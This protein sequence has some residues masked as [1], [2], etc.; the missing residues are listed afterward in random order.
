MDRLKQS[1]GSG[2]KLEWVCDEEEEDPW[3]TQPGTGTVR[4]D[5][6]PGLGLES[7]A[8]ILRVSAGSFFFF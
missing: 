3:P 2:S 8:D 5:T 4:R 7:V 1:Q 6:I